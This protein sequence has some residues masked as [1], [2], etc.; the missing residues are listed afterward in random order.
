MKTSALKRRAK[1]L[2]FG[3][4]ITQQSFGA[5]SRGWGAQVADRYQRRADVLN[6]GYS[7]YNTD[8]FLRLASTD[9]GRSDLFDHECVALVTIFLGANDASDPELNG[10]QHVPLGTYESNLGEIISLAR[11][12]FGEDVGIILIS[13]P[14]V[15]HEGRLRFQRE[16]YGEGAT[17][18][19]ERTIELSGKYAR[20][21]G[22]V[23]N[24][25]GVPFLDLWTN[26]QFTA[27]GEERENWRDF[28]SDGLHFSALGNEFVGAALLDVIDE[29][30]PQ[31]SVKPAP[32]TGNINSLS[33]CLA[34]PKIGPWHD[35]IDESG[36]AFD[37]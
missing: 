28:L 29:C 6:R 12:N 20:G 24:E 32:D 23:A 15:C 19:L 25:M 26:M 11:S 30:F 31:L 4:S 2:L 16:A 18:K 14:P 33:T 5:S 36:K 10:R 21:A 8:W 13:P 37:S 34:I 17:G 1:I 9:A 3:D 35:E 27:A 22:R 7:G